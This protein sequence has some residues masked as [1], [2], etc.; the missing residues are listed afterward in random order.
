VG[1]LNGDHLPDV[2][3]ANPDYGTGTMLNTGV[4]SFSPTHRL[5]LWALERRS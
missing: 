2:A 1:D 4:V 5:I 3:M